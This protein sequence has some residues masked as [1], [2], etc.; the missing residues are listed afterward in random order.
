MEKP[1]RPERGVPNRE[2]TEFTALG[3]PFAALFGL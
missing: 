2:T 3:L 1:E